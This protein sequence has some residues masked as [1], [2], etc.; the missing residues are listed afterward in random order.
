MP[1]SLDLT[2]NLEKYIVDHSEDLT[3]IQKETFLKKILQIQ[4]SLF[5]QN[6]PQGS[7]GGAGG[8]IRTQKI[9]R[10]PIPG[11]KKPQKP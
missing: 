9:V 2:D 3:D 5:P 11:S 1:K 8:S 4:N 6:R 7:V 10:N